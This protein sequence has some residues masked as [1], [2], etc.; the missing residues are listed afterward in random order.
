MTMYPSLANPAGSRAVV[1]DDSASIIEGD[2]IAT[3][4]F[5][6]C[7]TVRAWPD[8]ARHLI[9][10]DGVQ[11]HLEP[12]LFH[13]LATAIPALDQR[14]PAGRREEMAPR[15]P[16]SIPR[17]RLRLPTINP[18]GT[19]AGPDRL[20]SPFSRSPLGYLL[21]VLACLGIIAALTTGVVDPAELQALSGSHPIDNLPT[22]LV[23]LA[24]PA[25]R[26]AWALRGWFRFYR[27]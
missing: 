22:L 9:G 15:D 4:R 7:A 10:A 19:T 14:I 12:T 13:R 25:A 17:P 2:T 23:L 20:G 11:L 18:S 6:D 8:G 3:V 24:F 26:A 27:R 1:G 5:D 16:T 21:N